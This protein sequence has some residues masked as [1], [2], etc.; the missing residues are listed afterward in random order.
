MEQLNTQFTTQMSAGDR[1][2]V[3]QAVELAKK[4][5]GENSPAFVNGILSKFF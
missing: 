3:D 4:F 2:A 1:A 5:G